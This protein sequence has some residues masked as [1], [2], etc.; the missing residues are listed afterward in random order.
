MLIKVSV[1]ILGFMKVTDC[2][3]ALK[4]IH[5]ST[6]LPSETALHVY[7]SRAVIEVRVNIVSREQN[8]IN[9]VD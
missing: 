2:T 5:F 8:E 4:N 1:I 7:A 9:F 6:E 3:W